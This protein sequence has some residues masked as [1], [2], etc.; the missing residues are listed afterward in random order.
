M[1]TYQ[2]SY[3]KKG[4]EYRGGAGG[5]QRIVMWYTGSM[6]LIERRVVHLCMCK[7][8]KPSEY[9]LTIV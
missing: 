5:L 7:K 4:G 6:Q 1:H 9:V 2:Q 3:M 8:K